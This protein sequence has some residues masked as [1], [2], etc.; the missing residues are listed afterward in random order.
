MPLVED[1]EMARSKIPT[2]K[3]YRTKSTLRKALVVPIPLSLPIAID[4][5]YHFTKRRR[6]RGAI[7]FCFPFSTPKRL[8]YLCSALQHWPA[9][10]APGAL[11][12]LF[13][14]YTA[15]R[16]RESIH[17]PTRLIYPPEYT[18]GRVSRTCPEKKFRSDAIFFYCLP[19]RRYAGTTYARVVNANSRVAQLA[20][21]HGPSEDHETSSFSR[22]YAL[23]YY[24]DGF[25][26]RLPARSDAYSH[27]N[28]EQ[29]E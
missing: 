23:Q 2:K 15:S 28:R 27:K 29:K 4:K 25:T 14:S 17:F 16:R 19:E 9:A 1:T 13:P 8:T 24:S 7:K 20:V 5:G 6:D 22:L 26:S 11:L 12:L 10:E 21:F 18:L 3:K